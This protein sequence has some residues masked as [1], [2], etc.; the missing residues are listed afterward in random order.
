M[1]FGL[2]IT[3]G[4]AVLSVALRSYESS[5]SQKVGAFG[6]LTASFLGIYYITGSWILGPAQRAQLA[7]PALGGNPHPHSR[8]SFTERKIAAPEKSALRRNLPD[9]R[10]NLGADRKRRLRAC[11]RRRLG[12]G[13]LPAVLPALLQRGRSRAGH[14]LPERA[15]R[16]FV[17]LPA[18]LLAR[19]G[20]H[21]LDDLELSPLLR[22]KIEPAFSDQ[23]AAARSIFLAALPKPQT[24][25]A[26]PCR[27]NPI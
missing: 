10:R 19:A 25:P 2:F 3:L 21:D 7:V 18:D 4:V 15:E 11:Q 1:L 16:S 5:L 22:L 26:R 13:R 23:S 8:S 27:R 17:L 9:A 14:D 24:F 12:L 20:P 6:I